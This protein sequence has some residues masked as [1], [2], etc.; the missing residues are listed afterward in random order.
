MLTPASPPCR[1]GFARHMA[2]VKPYLYDL[3]GRLPPSPNRYVV[4]SRSQFSCAL[5]KRTFYSQ[6]RNP[7]AELVVSTGGKSS[8]RVP[9]RARAAQRCG[10]MLRE[11][12]QNHTRISVSSGQ[13]LDSFSTPP[14]PPPPQERQ[15]E[16]I[17]FPIRLEQYLMVGS[18]DH[19]LTARSHVPHK[20]YEY[21]LG[22]LLDTVRDAIAECMAVGYTSMT[23]GEAQKMMMMESPAELRAFAATHHQEWQVGPD[24]IVFKPV[25]F[26]EK[27]RTIPNIRVITEALSYATELERIV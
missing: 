17:S 18:Y 6:K 27:K 24:R 8:C 4:A 22:S 3:E 23:V 12:A 26:V 1:P 15:D 13:Y 21:F 16:C 7:G 25:G 14:P 9:L 10:E 20:Y 5:L 11:P 19:V 2:Q